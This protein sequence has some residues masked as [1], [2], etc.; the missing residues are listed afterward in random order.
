MLSVFLAVILTVLSH[1][2]TKESH[3]YYFLQS[4]LCLLCSLPCF[5]IFADRMKVFKFI[6]FLHF[7]LSHLYLLLFR[8]SSHSALTVYIICHAK[9][10][11]H[12]VNFNAVLILNC[13]SFF[14]RDIS[15][16]LPIDQT[17]KLM[18]CLLKEGSIYTFI[19]TTL[20]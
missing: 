10:L 13:S 2:V 15:F 16:F 7:L 18:D 17:V 9:G 19:E 12:L 1:Y 4:S 3:Y 14:Q 5:H 6:H 11:L 20:D 8:L